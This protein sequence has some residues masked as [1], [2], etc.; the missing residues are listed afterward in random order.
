[1]TDGFATHNIKHLSPS[2]L[3][4]WMAQPALWIM[5]RLLNHRA[6]VGCAAHR[7]TAVEAGI[8]AGLLNPAMP[9]AEC[10][11]IAMREFDKL[12]ALSVDPRRAKEREGLQG[13]V[14]TGLAELRQYG[15]PSSVQGRVEHRFEELSVPIMGFYD[16]RWDEH[17]VV[18][19]LKTTNRVPS[20]PSS[21]HARQVALYVHGTNAEGRLAYTSSNKI[22][23]YRV[24]NPAQHIA[25]LVNVA[26]RLGRFLAISPDPKEL[27]SLLTPDIDSFWFS[28][29]VARANAKAVYGL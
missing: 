23:V 2:S 18:V 21:Q 13:M 7:G 24:D 17:A 3:Y 11:D 16:F 25:D 19:D 8:A 12:T 26:Q 6:P 28:D 29:P 1:M 5:E 14:T 20:E 27:A 10:H 22:A 9:L 15:V 4:T